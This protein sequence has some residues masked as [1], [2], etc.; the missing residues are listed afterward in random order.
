MKISVQQYATSLY[1]LV[2]GAE[3]VKATEVLHSFVALLGRNRDLNL[4]PAIIAAFTDI[5][6]KENGE[7]VAE[8]TSARELGASSRETVINY[9]TKKSGAKTVVLN[10]K[11]DK[12]ILGGFVLKYNS[13]IVDGSLR[14]SLNELKGQME[15]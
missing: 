1:D 4:A 15:A 6:N 2:H 9:I 8:V 12:K 5:W 7:V 13:K 11:V 14:S 3:E 10:E